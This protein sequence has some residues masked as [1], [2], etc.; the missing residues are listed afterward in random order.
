VEAHRFLVIDRHFQRYVITFGAF[1]FLFHAAQEECAYPDLLHSGSHVNR[2]DPSYAM[3]G[4]SRAKP[5]SDNE[6]MYGGPNQRYKRDCRAPS[7]EIAHLF[8]RI[9]DSFYE[10]LVVD[11]HQAIEI[12]FLIAA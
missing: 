2:D 9:S 1:Q 3:S 8:F 5:V 11:F 10:A 12:T 7:Q 4:P 6:P